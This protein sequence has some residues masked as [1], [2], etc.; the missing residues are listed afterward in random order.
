MTLIDH[1][2]RPALRRRLRAEAHRLALY[3]LAYAWCHD[4]ALAD[5]LV[6]ETLL[7]ALDR[8]AQLRDPQ[9][10]KSW[11]CSILANCLRDHY[12]RTRTFEDIDELDEA[13]LSHADTPES[14]RESAQVVARVRDEVSRLPLGQRQVLTLVDLQECSYAEVA[15]ILDLP[16]GTVMSRLCRARAALKLRL[17]DAAP[18]SA[19]IGGN[20]RKTMRVVK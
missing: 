16:I 18:G 7:R 9:R 11:L 14:A 1:L 15:Q 19:A 13:V 6:Q 20:E 12:R 2:L 17:L 10:L 4:P 8:S 3:R 5:D